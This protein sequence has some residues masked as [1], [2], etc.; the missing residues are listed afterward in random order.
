M[1]SVTHIK[2]ACLASPSF[3]HFLILPGVRSWCLSRS[4]SSGQWFSDPPGES[5]GVLSSD[6]PPASGGSTLGSSPSWSCLENHIREVPRRFHN[7][8]SE[9]PQLLL[10]WKSIRST[11]SVQT[12]SYCLCEAISEFSHPMEG[13]QFESPRSF[14]SLP[15]ACIGVSKL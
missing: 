5:C 2:E 15:Q 6:R 3:I 9:P 7:L 13:A 11:P 12:S 8:I 1:H 4:P 10:K 14:L